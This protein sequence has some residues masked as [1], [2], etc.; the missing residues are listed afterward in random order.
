MARLPLPSHPGLLLLM[1]LIPMHV[2]LATYGRWVGVNWALFLPVS[3]MRLHDG[4]LLHRSAAL[5]ACRGTAAKRGAGKKKS[6]AAASPGP[7]AQSD[8]ESEPE[9]CAGDDS[10][11]F[12]EGCVWLAMSHP[13]PGD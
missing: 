13:G 3:S 8:T 1:L 4:P 6:V 12:S 7:S 5:P 9:P 11:D 10:D 2:C